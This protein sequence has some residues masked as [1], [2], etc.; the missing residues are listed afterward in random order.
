MA[1]SI[2]FPNW[3]ARAHAIRASGG[4]AN[5]IGNLSIA[6]GK[7]G[8]AYTASSNTASTLLTLIPTAGALIGAPAKELWVLYKLMPIA[9]L[10]SMMLSL[11]GNIVPME[12]NDYEQIDAFSYAGMIPTADQKINHAII[13]PTGETESERFAFQ[14]CLRAIDSRGARRTV[15]IWTGV[16]LQ[17]FWLACILIACW[18]LESGSIIVWWCTVSSEIQPPAV[19]VRTNLY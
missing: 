11:G 19:F 3:Q 18:F 13:Q 1:T 4:P 16:L 8:A 10:L 9:G 14:V 15:A 5:C 2:G 17:C 7:L 6:L 12:I